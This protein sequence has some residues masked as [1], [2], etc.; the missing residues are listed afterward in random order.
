[1]FNLHKHK[2]RSDSLVSFRFKRVRSWRILL[3]NNN[4]STS[5]LLPITCP[6]SRPYPSSPCIY[7]IPFLQSL[8]HSALFCSLLDTTSIIYVTTLNQDGQGTFLVIPSFSILLCPVPSV[9][10]QT[11]GP[12]HLLSC[13]PE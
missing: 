11:K 13:L 4:T 1:M 12:I 3:D 8:G 5:T 2:I 7:N 9:Y 6:L 10:H